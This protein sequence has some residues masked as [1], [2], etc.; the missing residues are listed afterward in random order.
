MTK[1]ARCEE[2]LDE[3]TVLVYFVVHKTKTVIEE[4]EFCKKCHPGSDAFYD[5]L[6]ASAEPISPEEAERLIKEEGYT[7]HVP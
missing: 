2:C 3:G 6:P 1:K 5:H 4:W 7:K